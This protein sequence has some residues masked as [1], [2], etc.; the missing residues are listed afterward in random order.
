[1]ASLVNSKGF[2]FPIVEQDSVIGSTGLV[3]YRRELGEDLEIVMLEMDV[4]QQEERVRARHEG[5]QHAVDIIR[6]GF[7]ISNRGM[8]ASKLCHR[9]ELVFG[10]IINLK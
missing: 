7:N 4:E 1:M 6:V 3:I 8:V 2:I 9:Q 5:S 10:P